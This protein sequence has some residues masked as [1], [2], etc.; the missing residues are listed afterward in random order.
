MLEKRKKSGNCFVIFWLISVGLFVLGGITLDSFEY[1]S[2]MIALS[3]VC[4]VIAL[5]GV[6]VDQY[7]KQDAWMKQREQDKEEERALRREMREHLAEQKRN[8]E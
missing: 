7:R 8:R 2:T 4:F 1:A 5:V 6:G 3:M